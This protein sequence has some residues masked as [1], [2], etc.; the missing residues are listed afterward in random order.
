MPSVYDFHHIELNNIGR[1]KKRVSI[2]SADGGIKSVLKEPQPR[3]TVELLS[4]SGDSPISQRSLASTPTH[5]RPA[6][7]RGSRCED[8]K[9]KLF[10]PAENSPRRVKNLFQSKIFTHD[11]VDS[12]CVTKIAATKAISTYTPIRRNPITGE[13]CSIQ[14]SPSRSN[15]VLL[16][17]PIAV[18]GNNSSSLPV[19][20]TFN[21]NNIITISPNGTTNNSQNLS[22]SSIASSCLSINSQN[23]SSSSPSQ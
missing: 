8:T 7:R 5:S 13:I 1:G 19:T 10:G 22:N 6:S 15:S 14:Q 20:P 3:N 9:T 2:S 23:S 4:S 11:T 12:A 17:K 21:R 16:K 18:N